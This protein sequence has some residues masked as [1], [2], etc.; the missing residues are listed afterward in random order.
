[1]T[2]SVDFVANNVKAVASCM[3][4][5]LNGTSVLEGEVPKDACLEVV[6]EDGISEVSDK[7]KANLGCNNLGRKTDGYAHYA[8][9]CLNGKAVV[10]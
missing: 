10:K 3:V 6:C 7:N 4:D 5:T 9:H 8:V 1:M 2:F